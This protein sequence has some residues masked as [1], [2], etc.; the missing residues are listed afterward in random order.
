MFTK[1][2]GRPPGPTAEGRATRERLFQAA[3]ALIRA[4][5]YEAATLRDVAKRARVSPGL[6]YRY[7]PSKRAVVLELYDRLS[8]DFAT[9]AARMRPGRW[10]DRAVFALRTSLAVLSP[11]REVLAALVPVLAGE[12]DDGLFAPR[13]AFS[14]RR[15]QEAFARAVDGADDAPEPRLAEAL[16]RLL[17][18]GHLL[19]LLGWVLDR[20]PRQRASARLVAMAARGLGWAPFALAFPGARPAVLSLDALIRDALGA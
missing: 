15:V 17:Y 20:S 10:G 19:V 3:T 14:R 5:G 13:T 1:K 12:G 11:H 7:F 16:G 2:R 4:K 8:A 18:V 9:R 6:L